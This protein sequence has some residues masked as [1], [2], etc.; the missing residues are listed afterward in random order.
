MRY[1]EK[2][3]LYIFP[4]L[5]LKRTPWESIWYEQERK[6]F[7]AGIR[8]FFGLAG[9]VYI[10]H[11]FAVDRVLNLQ[12]SDLWFQY[13]FS[14]AAI[15][16]FNLA[17]SYLP[18]F[19]RSSFYKI[20]TVISCAVFCYFQSRTILWYSAVPYLY[21]YA[22]VII[23]AIVIRENILNSTALSILLLI[24]ISPN[25][26]QAGQTPAMVFSA[27]VV[28]VIFIV[29]FKAKYVSDLNLFISTQRNLDSQK[30]LIEVNLE[31]T[32]QIKAFL[33]LEIAN[34]LTYFVQH[35][36][37]SV[38]Q[39]TDE[40]LR[41]RTMKVA[42]L[43][44]DVRGFTK[45]STDLTGFVSQ[46]LLPNIKASS[47]AAERFSGIPRK[48]GDLLFV[49]FD[50]PAYDVNILSAVR[51]AI[52]IHMINS[53]LNQ[54]LPLNLQVKRFLLL[55][56]GEAVVGNLSGFDSN[57]EITAIG[58]PVNFL[59]RLD[60][61][62]KNKILQNNLT[63]GDIL[64]SPEIAKELQRIHP[65]L[66]LSLF[67]VSA[68]NIKIRDFEDVAEIYLLPVT[69]KNYQ[70]LLPVELRTKLHDLKEAS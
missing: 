8:V 67:S 50:Q 63:A 32:N 9:F 29:F 54:T 24:L 5:S 34:R 19:A 61:L 31:F 33:P 16:F 37:M 62:T 14:M 56:S 39:A 38:L 3:I 55:S 26:I 40:V 12:P 30:K 2:L 27:S 49:Y 59:S 15:A 17:I 66:E 4:Q 44:S 47:R 28:T 43:F 70:L 25:T 51:T 6:E 23:S 46:A 11:Y 48:I 41:P 36:R 65:D 68:M 13:R 53:E 35:E 7:L 21:S 69:K 52:E 64:L 18:T 20:P 57:I 60:E 10:L 45:N 58:T 42:C 22:F 1:L